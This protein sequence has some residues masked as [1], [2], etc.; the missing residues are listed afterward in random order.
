MLITEDT[1]DYE[2][3]LTEDGDVGRTLPRSDGGGKK[4][5]ALTH[6]RMDLSVRRPAENPRVSILALF[7]DIGIINGA[8][9]QP[10]PRGVSIFVEGRTAKVWMLNSGMMVWFPLALAG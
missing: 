4:I 8:R 10:V 1:V 7:K 3:F 9:D 2:D 5:N 6:A